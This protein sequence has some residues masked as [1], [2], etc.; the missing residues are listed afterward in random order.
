MQLQATEIKHKHVYTHKH[1]HTNALH[2]SAHR[3]CY[4][5]ADAISPKHACT[6]STSTSAS[7]TP[8]L[9]NNK[10]TKSKPIME[11]ETKIETEIETVPS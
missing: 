9:Y 3:R 7:I 2:T 1:G 11:T 6:L 4:T 8:K 5:H 10:N